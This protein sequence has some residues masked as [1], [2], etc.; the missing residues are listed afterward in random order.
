VATSV[1]VGSILLARDHQLR[2]EQA[3]VRAGADLVDDI[4]LKIAV[5]GTG[6]VLALA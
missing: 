1:V 2:V 6:D 5:D 4:R 3:A